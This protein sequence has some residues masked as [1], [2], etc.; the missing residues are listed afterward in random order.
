[1]AETFKSLQRQRRRNANHS[2]SNHRKCNC[3]QTPRSLKF[4]IS[5]KA[6][7]GL[8]PVPP[9]TLSLHFKFILNLLSYQLYAA[10]VAN[11]RQP[12]RLKCT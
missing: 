6:G 2:I 1:M 8:Q 5:T 11:L 4:H 7:A 3:K 10:Q 9:R 12:K